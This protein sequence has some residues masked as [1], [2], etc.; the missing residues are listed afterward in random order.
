MSS[1]W[2]M[3]KPVKRGYKEKNRSGISFI[4]SYGPLRITIEPVTNHTPEWTDRKIT[5]SQAYVA[6]DYSEEDS[7]VSFNLRNN[8]TFLVQKGQKYFQIITDGRTETFFFF[9]GEK[10]LPE[11]D[12]LKTCV[13]IDTHHFS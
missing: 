7:Y 10:F 8:Q 5:C 4:G 13:Q 2:K 9:K 12:R 11:F 1:V 6:I 3:E